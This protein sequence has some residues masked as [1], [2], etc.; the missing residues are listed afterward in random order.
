MILRRSLRSLSE[1]GSLDAGVAPIP[2]R[3]RKT[4]FAVCPDASDLRITRTPSVGAVRAVLAGWN[5][6]P[7]SSAARTWSWPLVVVLLLARVACSRKVDSLACWSRVLQSLKGTKHAS[8]S[9]CTDLHSLSPKMPS[10]PH[11]VS[12]TPVT[13]FPAGKT[14]QGQGMLPKL[15]VPPLEDTMRRYVRALEGL[16]VRSSSLAVQLSSRP[17]GPLKGAQRS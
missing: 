13:H 7:A 10:R 8:Q 16:Q 4:H 17:H 5:S 14:F 11:T 15:P 3:P 6:G 1:A 9:N 12:S 2:R